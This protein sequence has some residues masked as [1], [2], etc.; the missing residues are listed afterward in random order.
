MPGAGW[1]RTTG[2]ESAS[3]TLQEGKLRLVEPQ[4]CRHFTAFDYSLQLCVGN[5]Q[6][7]K[8]AL[9]VILR[10]GSPPQIP[11]QGSEVSWKETESEACQPVRTEELE[12]SVPLQTGLLRPDAVSDHPTQ[13]AAWGSWVD[14]KERQEQ[15]QTE[16]QDP[17]RNEGSQI[18]C[19]V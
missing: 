1:E 12:L 13:A 5:P 9:T 8:P 2:E 16:T 6:K 17:M 15:H 10:R 19:W 14:R 11:V 4:A 18:G 3:R 7:T